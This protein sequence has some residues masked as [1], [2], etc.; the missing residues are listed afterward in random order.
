MPQQSMHSKLFQQPTT[1]C[2][3]PFSNDVYI[4]HEDGIKCAQQPEPACSAFYCQVDPEALRQ[5]AG[6]QQLPVQAQSVL[7]QLF[8][9]LQVDS[10]H[11]AGPPCT[12]HDVVPCITQSQDA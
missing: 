10:I 1:A 12:E 2:G 5:E 6:L 11:A 9:P 8:T 4:G 3:D 7:G